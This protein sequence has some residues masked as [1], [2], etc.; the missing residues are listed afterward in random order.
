MTHHEMPNRMMGSRFTIWKAR[1]GFVP[2]YLQ[3]FSWDPPRTP[4][5]EKIY[6]HLCR[7]AEVKHDPR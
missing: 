3:R 6:Q 2:A 4:G 5:Q 1:I 7:I